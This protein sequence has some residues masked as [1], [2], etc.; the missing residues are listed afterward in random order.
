[1][2]ID[3][4]M[5]IFGPALLDQ[6][7]GAIAGPPGK[8]GLAGGAS[9]ED[10]AKSLERDH[11]RLKLVTMALWEIL[12]EK[13]N[14]SEEE[15]RRKVT[16]LD[17]LDDRRDGRLKIKQ[18]PTRCGACDRPMLNSAVACVYCGV[19]RADLPLFP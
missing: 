5:D 7:K 14:V 16:E 2:M 18:P 6:A 19:E 17:L 8:G 11:E 3:L 9:P 15:L 12:S 1:M 4:I 13:L 10:R